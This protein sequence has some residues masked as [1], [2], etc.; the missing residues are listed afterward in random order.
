MDLFQKC[1]DFTRADAAIAAG[2][3]PYFQVIEENHGAVV[4]MEG[5]DVVMAGSN[6]YLGLSQHPEVIEAAKASAS[7]TTTS[8][9]VG[10]RASGMVPRSRSAP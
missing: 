5:H 8:H 7:W 1:R 6:D 2:L 4:R 10:R 9:T 3:F